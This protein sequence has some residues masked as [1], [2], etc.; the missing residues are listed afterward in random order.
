MAALHSGRSQVGSALPH[1]CEVPVSAIAIIGMSC[2][3]A[4]ANHLG[5]YW[6]MTREGRHGFGPVPEDRWAH[7]AFFSEN[8]RNPDRS[9]AP[10][11][12]FIKDVR[13]FPALSLGIP[14]RRVEVMDP[15]QRFAI[16]MSLAAI[17]D[18][19]LRPSDM[20]RR[21]GV[22]MGITANEFR[23][24]V[25]ARVAAKL[26][27]TGALGEPGDPDVLADAVG[28]VVPCRPFSAAGVLTNM[29]AASVAQELDLHGPAFTVD[30]ACASGLI[31]VA[32]A[33]ER[34]DSGS[35]DAALAGGIYLCL[36]PEHHVAFSRIGAISAS[37]VCRPFD[38]R[39]DGFV[40]GDGASVVVLKRLADAERDGDRIYAVIDGVA[41]NNDGHGDGPMA[42]V[43]AGQAEVI[44]DAWAR[45]SISPSRLGYVEAHGT[46]TS[47]GDRVEL[48]GLSEAL[49]SEVQSAALGSSKANVGHTMS[50]AGIA[51]LVRAVLAI[52]HKTIPPMANFEASKSEIG[53]AKTPFRVP[54]QAEPWRTDDRVAAVSSFGFGGT[55]A[56]VVLRNVQTARPQPKAQAELVLLSAGDEA[57]LRALAGQIAE[58]MAAD[59][60]LSVAAVAKATARRKHEAARLG[61]VATTPTELIDALSEISGGGLPKGAALGHANGK[62]RIGFLFPGQGAQRVGMLRDSVQRYPIVRD[63]LAAMAATLEGE[64]ATPLLELLY[65]A[66]ATEEAAQRL[67]ATQNCQPAIFA[68]SEALRLLLQSVGVVPHAVAGHSLGEFNAAV[69]AGVLDAQDAARFVARRGAAMAAVDG[70]CG[71]MLAVLADAP[72]TQSLLVDGAVVANFNHPA[73][74]VVSGTTAAVAAVAARAKEAGVAAKPV[75]VSHAFHSPIFAD[76]DIA[77]L[78]D[79]LP[80]SDPTMPVAS[81]IAPQPYRSAA[82]ARAVFA[83]HAASPVRFVSAIEQCAEAGVDLYLQVGAGGPLASFA[84][85]SAGVDGVRAVLTL[86]GRDDDDSGSQIL[87]TLAWLFVH[88]APVDPSALTADATPACLPPTPRARQVYW[89]IH[90][91][92]P[93]RR[94]DLGSKRVAR[95]APPAEAAPA[96]PAVDAAPDHTTDTKVVQI[97][98][99][100]SS[101]PTAAIRPES[102]LVDDLGFDSLMVA[103]LGTGLAD[104]F[105]GLG[106]LPQELLINRPTVADIV[107]HVTATLMGP[108]AADTDDDAPLLPFVP[109][110]RSSPLPD[111]PSTLKGVRFSLGAHAE[112]ALHAALEAAGAVAASEADATLLVHIESSSAAPV[113]AVLAGEAPGVHRAEGLLNRLT[114]R[115]AVGEVDLLLLLDGDDPW[116]A[117]LAGAARA[118]AREWPQRS[119]RAVEL[120]GGLSV[121]QAAARLTHELTSD[122]RTVD[123]RL[124]ADGCRSVAGLRA[125]GLDP[126][127]NAIGADDTVLITGG[128]SGIG[129]RLAERLAPTG[130]RI[131]LVSRS[132]A[133]EAA[134]KL[135]E[136]DRV[137]AIAADVTDR[138]AL[139]VALSELHPITALVHAAGL[140]ADG[141]LAT[142]DADRAGLARRVKVDGWLN[143]IVAAGP[144]LQRA[145][146]IGSW[147]GRFGNRH[148]VHYASAN[149]AMAGIS[150]DVPAR[151][152]A[153]VAEFGPWTNSEMVRTIPAPVAASMR[154]EGV[155]FVGDEAG[156]DCL[157]SCLR[158]GSG[159]VVFGRDLPDTSRTVVHRTTL[160]LD[161]HPYL[162]DHT[163]D[164][165][166]VFP[167]AAATDLLAHAAALAPPFVVE[168]LRLYTGIT[169][170]ETTPITV[171]VRGDRGEIRVGE[172][173]A[174]AYRARIRTFQGPVEVPSTPGKGQPLALSL[175]AFYDEVTF[176]G[177]LL[178]GIV[179]IGGVGED[180]AHGR[181]RTSTPSD[182][183][184]G[185][186]RS[187]WA[188]DPLTLDSAMQLA[189]AVAWVRYQRAGTPV[190]LGRYV[191]LKPMPQGPISV[192]AR[193]GEANEDRFVADFVLRDGSGKPVALVEAATAQLTKAEGADAAPVLDLKP[194]WTSPES[195]PEVKDMAMRLQMATAS[196]IRNPYFAVHEGTARNVTRVSGT[197]LVNFSSYNYLG[198]SG[199]PRVL[200]EVGEAIERYGTSVSASRVASGERPFHVALEREL[201]SAQGAEDALVFTAGHATN[202][203]TIGHLFG[204]KDLVLHDELIH[205]SILQ[206]IKLS[207]AGRRGFRHDDPEHLAQLLT[208]LRAHHER[209]LI[210]VEGVY[211]MDGDICQLPAYVELKKKFG[212]LLMV[213]EAHS[214]GVVGA[215]GRGVAE[216]YGIDGREVDL[217][218]G[219]LSKSLASCGG[220]IAG[221]KALM[222][223]LRYTAPGFVYSA[224]ITPANGVAALASL[225]LMLA[226]PERVV[227]LQ[228]NAKV[229]HNALVARGVNT[230]PALGESA[231]VPV[232]TGNSLHA[233]LLSQGLYDRGINVQPIVY[234]AVA[235]D[236]ARLR[237]FLSSTH[238]EDQLVFTAERIASTSA[239]VRAAHPLPP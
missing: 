95:T 177:P 58:L 193:F 214:F 228:R 60:E 152:R 160:G 123:V 198:L 180:F 178:A 212:T 69:A 81:C 32:D 94:L 105:P 208:K 50:A 163:I 185:S 100:V 156:L 87:R 112:P 167:L 155:D 21:T 134:A 120:E 138:A 181:V 215:R 139:Q 89:P 189:A 131:I 47:V 190:S 92:K 108:G 101:Y 170:K 196:G 165:V 171:T 133:T 104:A 71:A 29:N 221:S 67:T 183:M 17:E 140:L 239:E 142:V 72:T 20:P 136:S 8:R 102:V 28:G 201:A 168:D 218:M 169:V 2:R 111:A 49:G 132:G 24:L 129:L 207:G 6:H 231:V 210:V 188:V 119:V 199:D 103:D 229:F 238:T 122:D 79:A 35:I 114:A 56:H 162:A 143:S 236:A 158:G 182:W 78:V 234:P 109:V 18:A 204:P 98:A 192:A 7:E 135:L 126:V 173:N 164:G 39:A 34:L 148:Q 85:K 176:H 191:Q 200:A 12:A 41:I 174:L 5:A 70:D 172:R 75:V 118:L 93:T 99:R 159:S 127:D 23:G 68:C 161:T 86:G 26:M 1:S 175:K 57:S 3:F 14:P 225:R 97:I 194:E 52:H 150:A 202:V 128:T 219:T 203:T 73:Q 27:A 211:S 62:P 213:D 31:A 233:Q 82:E 74:H 107:G 84:R 44:R 40:Q 59:A 222:T 4:D 115:A 51:G 224:G 96:Q 106:G 30:A 116:R 22:F 76:L 216:H 157:L 110:W 42:P 88:G 149:A 217:W 137:H 226:E 227:T 209:V 61:V 25:N 65:P 153:V 66:D 113:A 46:G 144:A 220:W 48:A 235:D 141:A 13:S 230:G 179:E 154:A 37:G 19:G 147:A 55:N 197:E 64:L 36:T 124:M 223:Y 130:A 117:A 146:A 91:D 184:V 77:P 151:I 187:G 45:S 83:V 10:T 145:V 121:A 232:V 11:G 33:V 186:E 206:G 90:H 80:V 125:G 166:P 237:F 43:Q 53:I 63:T 9:Y 54:V 205:D 15:Q 38:H 195:W 16:E